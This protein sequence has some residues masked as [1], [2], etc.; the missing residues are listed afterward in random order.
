MVVVDG[1]IIIP[2]IHF[3]TVHLLFVLSSLKHGMV[4]MESV[5]FTYFQ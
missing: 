2:F 1:S 4:A 5:N 3:I